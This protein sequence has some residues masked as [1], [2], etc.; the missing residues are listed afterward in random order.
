MLHW[1]AA[2]QGHS[3][4]MYYAFSSYDLGDLVYD[5]ILIIPDMLALD[6]HDV[7][8]E[9]MMMICKISE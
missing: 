5:A 4:I 7:V 6:V 3:T 1:F 9:N 2:L 8:S